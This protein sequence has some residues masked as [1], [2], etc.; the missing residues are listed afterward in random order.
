MIMF[1]S[2][3]VS[4]VFLVME[5]SG[6]LFIYKNKGRPTAADARAILVDPELR[7]K[8]NN[9]KKRTKMKNGTDIL[10]S[11]SV[12]S[13]K[14]IHSMH[15]FP[16]ILYMDLTSCTDKEGQYLFLAVNKYDNGHTFIVNA[17][18]LPCQ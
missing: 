16:E 1:P 7:T 12:A 14:M 9:L 15:M 2:L 11:L 18:V 3:G 8:L 5:K 17:T 10:L 4:Q 13:D 6:S